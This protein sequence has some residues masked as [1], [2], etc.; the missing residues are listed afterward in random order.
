MARIE[1]SAE[2]IQRGLPPCCV[3][4]GELTDD[5]REL[6]IERPVAIRRVSVPLCEDH[7]LWMNS[8]IWCISPTGAVVLILA[9]AGA[10]SVQ[11]PPFLIA[12]VVGFVW[13]IVG[14]LLQSYWPPRAIWASRHDT[15]VLHNIHRQFRAALW[16]RRD[17]GEEAEEP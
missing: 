15:I 8:L 10:C 11:F 13:M 12:M 16:D 5:W 17:E 9:T 4:C 7:S 1:I 6:L 3:Y 2:D 14:G